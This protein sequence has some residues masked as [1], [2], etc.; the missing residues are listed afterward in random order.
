MPKPF[1]AMNGSGMH[2]HMS[3]FESGKNL[4]A[5]EAYKKAFIAGLLEHAAEISAVV[6]PTVNSYKRLVPGYEAP[7]YICWGY[8]NRSALVRVPKADSEKNARVEFRSPDPSCNPYLAFALLLMA[9]LD[10][11]DKNLDP[12][13]PQKENVYK[14]SE[15]ELGERGIQTLPNNLWEAIREFENSKLA[16]R[17][18]GQ[19]L[20]DRY[21]KEKEKEWNSYLAATGG[22][23]NQVTCW[24]LERYL[25]V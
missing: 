17:I 12:P 14:L 9:G 3:V 6:S 11:V 23:N 2:L 7:V 21:V 19:N 1:Y 8:A 10:G 25:N 15:K 22:I 16:K 5:D 4:L 13:E 20:M 24:E 18:L